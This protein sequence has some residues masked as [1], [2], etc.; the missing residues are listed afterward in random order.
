MSRSVAQLSSREFPRLKP[1]PEIVPNGIDTQLFRPS[2]AQPGRELVFV[3]TCKA[4]KGY[5]QLLRALP[6][7]MGRFPDLC[8]RIAG[9]GAE[10]NALGLPEALA[11]RVIFEG[12]VERES[13]P[14]VYASASVCVLPSLTEAFGLTMAEAMSCGVPVVGSRLGAGPELARDGDEALLVDPRNARELASAII[15]CVED[16]DL[17]G[18]L[19]ARARTRAVESFSW[20]QVVLRNERLFE[21]VYRK[22]AAWAQSA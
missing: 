22:E 12:F 2:C 4:A 18:R 15:R 3:G 11:S 7:V 17:R 14:E 13:L 20:E 5:S 8:V 6:V 21:G 19:S 9:R 16:A 10:R 1:T